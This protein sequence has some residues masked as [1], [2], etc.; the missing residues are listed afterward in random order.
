M[1]VYLAT[2][3]GTPHFH[4]LCGPG[5]TKL[6]CRNITLKDEVTAIQVLVGPETEMTAV[7]VCT[8]SSGASVTQI[9]HIQFYHTSTEITFNTFFK[10]RT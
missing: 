5:S 7:L 9:K 4:L 6:P 3:N 8:D 10:V 1:T 2:S